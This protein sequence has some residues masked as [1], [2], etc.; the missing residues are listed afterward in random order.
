LA[1]TLSALRPIVEAWEWQSVG[2]CREPGGTQFFH[3][4]EDLG[5]I[6]RRLREAAA[7]RLCQSCPVRAECLTHALTVGEEY[8][9]WGGF[10]ETDR[11][12]LRDVGWRDT[13]GEDR[14]VDVGRL[15]QRVDRVRARPGSRGPAG[16]VATSA[17]GRQ[18]PGPTLVRPRTGG[19]LLRPLEHAAER[20]TL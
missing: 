17:V 7:T 20:S 5:R 16:A 4:D 18:R 12:A 9:V 13:V 6:S 15:R 1:R 19:E 11:S 3:P 8:G 10:T 2:R 14:L